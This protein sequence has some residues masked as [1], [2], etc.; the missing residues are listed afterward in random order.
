M[1]GGFGGAGFQQS[2]STLSAR[3]S[4]RSAIRNIGYRRRRTRHH[5]QEWPGAPRRCR[6]PRRTPTTSRNATRR[7]EVT[8]L[9]PQG[10]SLR[11]MRAARGL[12]ASTQPS[13]WARKSTA[14]RAVID[15]K[16]CISKSPHARIS[17]IKA[18][19]ADELGKPHLSAGARNF[20]PIMACGK[21]H[22]R[23]SGRNRSVVPSSRKCHHTAIF[24]HRIVQAK[25]LRYAG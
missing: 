12:L 4:K 7:G 17:L 15:G 10:D 13:A 9:V 2:D 25:G 19:K 11:T 22:H 3:A 21:H 14:R 5:V 8:A 20:N 1:F 16:R 23:G 24:V 18:E 6:F